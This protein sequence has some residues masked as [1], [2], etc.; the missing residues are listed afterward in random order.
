MTKITKILPVLVCDALHIRINLQPAKFVIKKRNCSE[1]N[2]K[3]NTYFT[4][5]VLHYT[6]KVTG[7]AF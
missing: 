3:L 1:Y 5:I 6:A 4:Y 2:D 7:L